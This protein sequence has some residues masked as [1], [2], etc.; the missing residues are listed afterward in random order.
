[1]D[2]FRL[3][4]ALL[5]LLAVSLFS[6][7]A[8]ESNA[9]T[10]VDGK[11]VFL[12]NCASCH[13][14]D[15]NA[16]PAPDLVTGSLQ[17]RYTTDQLTNYLKKNMPKSNPGSLSDEEYRAIASFLLDLNVAEANK[18]Q[19]PPPEKTDDIT[20]LVD[21]K[22]LSFPEPPRNIKGTVLVPL[23]EIFE[24]LGAK[25]SWD[26]KTKT[27]KATKQ[28]ITVTLTIGKS[29]ATVNKKSVK[30]SQPAQL[31]NGKTFVPLRFVSESLGAKV[32]WDG[33][34]QTVTVT[35]R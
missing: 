12:A 25:V 32:E 7:S 11:A 27:V 10:P 13:G 33:S 6:F 28:N 1:M 24:A 5:I 4:L 17:I 3:A 18:P 22:K 2:L 31:I 9:S 21:G 30:L 16:G 34:T 20:V 19:T 15:G 8:E 29:V 23:R 26:G 14:T 35:S